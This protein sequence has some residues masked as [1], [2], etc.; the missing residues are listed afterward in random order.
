MGANVQQQQQP[1]APTP[2]LNPQQA[3]D[4][5]KIQALQGVAS[6]GYYKGNAPGG[7]AMQGVTQLAAALMGKQAMNDWQKKWGVQ[8]PNGAGTGNP[9]LNP[10]QPTQTVV[11]LPGNPQQ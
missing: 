1:M 5:A 10:P 7:G 11:P 6:Q 4:M 8:T 9:A 3:A 2:G